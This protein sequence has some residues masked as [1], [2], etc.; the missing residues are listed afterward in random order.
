[1]FTKFV[2]YALLMKRK[3]TQ[4][5]ILPYFQVLLVC[6]LIFSSCKKEGSIGLGVQPATDLVI[7]EFKDTSTVLSYIIREDSVN[8]NNI[9]YAVLGS[10]NDPVFGTAAAALFTQL[11]LPGNQTAVDLTGGVGTQAELV[12]D[13]VVLSF[14]YTS[15]LPNLRRYYG[16]LETQTF[17]VY[18]ITKAMSTD[19]TYR[20]NTLMPYDSL[21]PIGTI[22]FTPKPDSL[23]TIKG[24]K[25]NAHLRLKLDSA[26]GADI[27]SKSGGTELSST[28][29]F[30]A[31]LKG[32]AIVPVNGTQTSG[33]GAVFYFYLGGAETRLNFYYRRNTTT[34]L[35]G[36]T[37]TFSLEINST[38]SHFS[39]FKHN[40]AGTPFEFKMD[41]TPDTDYIY[42]QSMAGIKTKIVFPYLNGLNAGNSVAINKANLLIKV[43][44]STVSTQY[45]T[46]PQLF[47]MAIDSTGNSSFPL[48]YFDTQMGY[49]GAYVAT[50]Q[51]YS[52]NITRHLQWIIQ[53]KIKNYGFYLLAAGSAVNGAREVMTGAGKNSN[54]LKLR[55]T[56]TKIN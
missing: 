48:D 39:Q 25:H 43:D 8:T 2:R 26:F 45:D 42:V 54:K 11:S 46:H 19:S 16:T 20:S 5:S 6:A 31:Y 9:D 18:K 12:L 27:I 55:L 38:A 24:V 4:S 49:G 17:K 35:T 52:F 3:P 53:G 14:E 10:Y 15:T 29:A 50:T 32:L 40:Y 30:Q 51:E 23:V 37:L 34:P 7:S 56:Y 47:L 36:D 13:S 44:P 22:N 33:T 1:M 41:N 21:N 28:A